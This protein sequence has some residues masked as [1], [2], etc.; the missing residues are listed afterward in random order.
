[1]FRKNRIFIRLSVF[2]LTHFCGT[3]E[4]LR[5]VKTVFLISE[6]TKHKRLVYKI[7]L[8]TS[9]QYILILNFNFYIFLL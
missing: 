8:Q 5:Y 9:A 4:I 1:M 2:I 6:S 7:N 3:A